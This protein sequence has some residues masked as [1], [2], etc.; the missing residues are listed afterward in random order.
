MRIS[1]LCALKVNDVN[2]Y[3]KN[4]LIYGKSAKERRIQIGNDDVVRA[5]QKYKDAFEENIQ[6]C[7]HFF[8][9]QTGRTLSDQSDRR[10]INKYTALAAMKQ[11]ITPHMFRHSNIKHKTKILIWQNSIL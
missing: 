1:E 11:H 10:M 2:L 7:G 3:D 9:N 6:K 4:V 8:A 5:L